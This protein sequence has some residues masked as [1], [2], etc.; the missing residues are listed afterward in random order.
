[1]P[2]GDAGVRTKWR[3]LNV[4]SAIKNCIVTVKAALNYLAYALIIAMGLVNGDTKSQS[5]RNSRGLEKPV[6][7]ILKA[8]GVDLYNGGTFEE[9]RQF[10]DQLSDYQIIVFEY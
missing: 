2:A 3:S 10:Q 9:F 6:E 5:Y 1:M 8:S 4:M 7:H